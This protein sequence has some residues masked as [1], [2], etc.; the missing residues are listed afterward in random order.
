MQRRHTPVQSRCR[1]L[2]GYNIHGQLG[3]G[4]NV[5][6]TVPTA[7]STALVTSW[8]AISAG[9]VMSCGLAAGGSLDYKAFC[10][11]ESPRRPAMDPP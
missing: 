3:D 9:K 4:A 2:A 5:D 1:D 6:K 11:G 8:R 10:W 7:V